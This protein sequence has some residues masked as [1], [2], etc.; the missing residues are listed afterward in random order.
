MTAGNGSS[1]P[2][3]ATSTA[4]AGS[5]EA[6]IQIAPTPPAP[7]PAITA[8]DSTPTHAP[9]S[10]EE[11]LIG[12]IQILDRALI[13]LTLAFAFCLGSFR[14]SNSDLW[15]HLASGRGIAKG[16]YAFWSGV[17]PFAHTTTGEHWDNHAWLSDLIAYE[18]AQVFGGPE[19]SAGG[20]ALVVLKALLLMALAGVMLLIRRPSQGFWIP[21]VCTALALL[22]MSPRFFLQPT[23]VSFLFLGLT[24]YLLQRPEGIT[25]AERAALPK[26]R[27]WLA[28]TDRRYALPV[29]FVLWVNLDGWYLI[30]P[31]TVGLY[32]LGE[33]LQDRFAR[34]HGGVDAPLPGEMK[35]LGIVT[36][37]SFAAL[38][39][40]P[41]HVRSFTL[42]A[43]L[44]AFLSDSMLRE[45]DWFSSFFYSSFDEKILAPNNVELYQN[46]ASLAFLP[47]LLFS[48]VSFLCNL[49]GVRWWRVAVYVPFAILAACWMRAV[50]YFAIIAGPVMALN[51]QD[52]AVQWAV[53]GP[54]KVGRFPK[55]LVGRLGTVLALGIL[56]ALAWP[57]LLHPRADDARYTRRVTWGITT[58][59]SFRHL[60]AT[61]AD[62]RSKGVLR[63]ESRAFNLNPE[64]ANYCAWYCPEE[65][66]YFDLRMSPYSDK[67]IGDYVRTRLELEY[68]ETKSAEASRSADK[69]RE[70]PTDRVYPT[71][72]RADKNAPIDHV[73]VSGMEWNHLRKTVLLRFWSD[74][75]QWK[76]LYGDGRTMVFGW[77]DPER[78]GKDRFASAEFDPIPLA[79]A[80]DLKPAAADDRE[81]E[82]KHESRDAATATTWWA[83]YTKVPES[84]SPALDEAEMLRDYFVVPQ[85]RLQERQ[86][87]VNL[88]QA[89]GSEPL[90]A[91]GQAT[92]ASFA[93]LSAKL[94]TLVWAARLPVS[95]EMSA[96]RLLG[97][98]SA[99]KAIHENPNEALAYYDAARATEM[100]GR[101]QLDM[102]QGRRPAYGLLDDIRQI[103][104]VNSLT[105]AVMLKPD[106]TDAHLELARVFAST[107]MILNNQAYPTHLELHLIHLA[108]WA[109]LARADAAQLRDNEAIQSR[110]RQ[111][112]QEL[113]RSMSICARVG[114]QLARAA[115]TE[116][117][118]RDPEALRRRL[119]SACALKTENQPAYMRMSMALQFGLA[120]Q[121]LEISR[122]LDLTDLR[123]TLPREHFDQLYNLIILLRIK[124]GVAEEA[125]GAE[126]RL[127]DNWL[128]TL[129]ALARGD[130]VQA[131]QYLADRGARFE[132]AQ[133]GA[134][135]RLF[136]STLTSL[137]SHPA[138]LQFMSEIARLKREECDVRVLRGLVALEH[139]D[140]VTAR[141][142]FDRA[143]RATLPAG[144]MPKLVGL[145][146][147]GTP[148][149]EATY[150]HAAQSSGE[151]RFG[152][153]LAPLAA[154]YVQQMKEA[155]AREK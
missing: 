125:E 141:K 1:E 102:G 85:Y 147:T 87:F 13:V 138:N 127:V 107:H 91:S 59:E 124:S 150:I 84:R 90:M 44:S 43:E 149:E 25:A 16:D 95:T 62:L 128:L 48:L 5:A 32:A 108:R 21:A 17:D 27:R 121:A 69:P 63:P 105:R 56:I 117:E 8:G 113:K 61:L 88:A 126:E 3:P 114:T 30:G 19:S 18:V 153:D 140:N 116:E 15:M 2:N 42:P 76:M 36:A 144:Q 49:R 109:E 79:F 130:Y 64:A 75:P 77:S 29:L 12:E 46:A 154:A 99:R 26:W 58:N 98:R 39:L 31:I 34:I 155:A 151:H 104:A 47:L 35:Q 96:V 20:A 152:F 40:S 143:L 120:Q 97:V 148:M 133:R 142:H 71:V 103:Q 137:H 146:G 33:W 45:D 118:R 110:Q 94:N 4:D 89:V 28:T 37:A 119:R 101:L 106:F 80:P 51:F 139:G 55:P 9:T 14:A 131:D 50:P 135:L 54:A 10:R 11:R 41:Y 52:F 23:C 24:L 38:V 68:R 100:L 132:Q 136:G 82:E 111:I 86:N 67:V 78:P 93:G 70:R 92:G 7:P 60:G 65:K 81:L 112:E 123:K 73:I 66:C 115:L 74:P 6:T 145:F 57:G 22:A 129:I 53:R 122:D 83:Y 134:M 72:F